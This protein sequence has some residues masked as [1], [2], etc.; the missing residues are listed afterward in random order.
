MET[1]A[2][3]KNPEARS[4]LA[5]IRSPHQQRVDAF[6]RGIPGQRVPMDGP[7]IPTAEGRELRTR[8]IIE[9]SWEA[10]NGMR[11]EVSVRG[12][13]TMDIKK[14]EEF[15][16]QVNFPSLV[17]EDAHVVMEH[18]FHALEIPVMGPVSDSYMREVADGCLDIIVV[19]TGTLTAHGI[20]DYLLQEEVDLN[21]L[22]K[23]AEGHRIDDGG[24]LIKPPGHP[25]PDIQGI[26]DA[27]APF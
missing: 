13:A 19:T 23:F 18:S 25:L 27:Q 11:V 22:L 6:M 2:L 24:K 26:L 20:A 5:K 14:G 10:I 7:L 8:L 4:G 1:L 16:M 17:H 12:V 3:I 21:N 15:T 9:E